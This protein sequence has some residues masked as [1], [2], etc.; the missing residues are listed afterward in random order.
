MNVKKNRDIMDR[1]LC[2]LGFHHWEH[3]G[4]DVWSE[5]WDEDAPLSVHYSSHRKCSKCE[6]RSTSYSKEGIPPEVQ[7]NVDLSS[8]VD[9]SVA[10][11]DPKPLLQRE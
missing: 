10:Y 3:I 6:K 2:G 7:I 11:M 5:K 1:L 4:Y 9:H 8:F